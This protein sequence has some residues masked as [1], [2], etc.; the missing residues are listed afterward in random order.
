MLIKSII[1]LMLIAML[2]SLFSALYFMFTDK[3]RGTRTVKALTF[4]IGIWVVLLALLALGT[5][6]GVL[7]PI[8][9][10]VP[11]VADRQAH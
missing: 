8:N 5:A 4:R 11:P 1:I 6:T 3:G 9:S 7:K 10:I 2:V